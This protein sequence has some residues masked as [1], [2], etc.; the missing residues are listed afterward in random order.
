LR[1][2]SSNL[3]LFILS[4][5]STHVNY[6]FGGT[7]RPAAAAFLLPCGAPLVN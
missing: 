6:Y 1:F 3:K 4:I 7:P 2:E 5:P